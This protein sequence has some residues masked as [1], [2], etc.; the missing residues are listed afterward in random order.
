MGDG[1]RREVSNRQ[2]PGAKA[3]ESGS[4]DIPGRRG[5]QAPIGKFERGRHRRAWIGAATGTCRGD[6]ARHD[7]SNRSVQ[8]AN[9]GA[10]RASSGA[11]RGGGTRREV[12]NRPSPAA[13]AR[14]DQGDDENESSGESDPFA[15]LALGVLRVIV[16][17]QGR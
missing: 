7:F 13:I 11:N 10:D 15:A 14:A 8:A 16:R 9:F 2:A 3:A 12:S 1:A 5:N 17:G 4:P 6:D